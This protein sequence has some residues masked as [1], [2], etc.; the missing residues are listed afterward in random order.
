MNIAWKR[1][2]RSDGRNFCGRQVYQPTAEIH[3]RTGR[4]ESVRI[5]IG[6]PINL[7]PPPITSPKKQFLMRRVGIRSLPHRKRLIGQVPKPIV[8]II[9]GP[10]A[11]RWDWPFT[12]LTIAGFESNRPKEPYREQSSKVRAIAE[13]SIHRAA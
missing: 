1:R 12:I 10:T 13:G 9:S 4:S 2:R 11:E 3:I 6:R 5:R 8:S 7:Q